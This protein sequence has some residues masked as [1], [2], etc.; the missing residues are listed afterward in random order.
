[1]ADIVHSNVH[2]WGKISL[3]N[4][5]FLCILHVL[6]ELGGQCNKNLGNAFVVIWR[7]GDE[8]FLLQ[9]TTGPSTTARKNMFSRPS[10]YTQDN[11]GEDVVRN[12]RK[13]L[14]QPLDLRR[15][16]GLDNM[17][18][19]ALICFL[20][21]IAEINRNKHVLSYRTDPRLTDNEKSLYKVRMGFGL[22]V[23]WAIEGA[24][25]SLFK[26]DATYLSPHV[27]IAARLET[28]S[29][30]YGVPLLLSEVSIRFLNVYR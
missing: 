14:G 26:V 25:G 21:V 6:L 2:N 3:M 17:A 30:Q 5:F 23:G 18:D 22:H 12:R 15:V 28:A 8:D 24:V 10:F 11:D 27:N 4:L 13:K 20:K 16:P 1:M 9:Q 19:Q 29:R 7:I